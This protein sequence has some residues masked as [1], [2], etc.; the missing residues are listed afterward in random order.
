MGEGIA[1]DYLATL[2]WHVCA[3]NW[4]TRYGELDLIAR[5]P[6]P[7]GGADILVVVEV[8][9]RRNGAVYGDPVAAVT[10]DKL[11]RMTRLAWMW[12][13]EQREFGELEYFDSL[14]Y[15]VISIR[16]DGAAGAPLLRHHRG[17]VD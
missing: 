15:D 12:I 5:E 6:N 7:S 4:R 2:G 16:M 9:T 17:V 1:A 8:K 13:G 10:E 14:R 3:R 11:A